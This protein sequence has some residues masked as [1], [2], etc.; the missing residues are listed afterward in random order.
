MRLI[1][2]YKCSKFDAYFRN[3][4]KLQKIF[5][6]FE[7]N[8]FELISLNTNLYREKLRVIGS[9]YVNKQSQNLRYYEEIF[10]PK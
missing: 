1:F 4:E 9:I 2:F 7:E 6:A 5:W 10:F 8:T 3:S